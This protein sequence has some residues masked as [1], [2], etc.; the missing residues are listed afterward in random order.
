V[1]TVPFNG[2][3]DYEVFSKITERQM[4]FPLDLESDTVDII[5]KLL[6]LDPN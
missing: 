6:N 2:Q 4:S 3:F 5:D 1:G